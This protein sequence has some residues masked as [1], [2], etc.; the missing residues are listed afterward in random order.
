MSAFT[1]HSRPFRTAVA[2]ALLLAVVSGDVSAQYFGPNK[3]RWR[4][5]D[6]KVLQTEHFDIH[7]YPEAESAVQ[8]A[9]RLAERWYTR[10]ATVLEHQLSSRQPLILYAAHPH[11]QQTNVIQGFIGVGTGGVT[12]ALRR[13]I[14]LPFGA[15]GA[16]T[17]HVIGHE[18]VH[19]F[20]FDLASNTRERGLNLPLW[21]VEGMAEYLSIGP[22]DPHTAMW[23]RDAALNDRLPRVADLDNPEFF[24]YRF[25]Q[26]FWSYV[27][28]RWGDDIVG[29]AFRLALSVGPIPVLERLTGLTEEELSA[30][31]HAAIRESYGSV[32]QSRIVPADTGRPLFPDQ[33]EDEVTIAPALS[34][35]GRR[36][37]VLS[38]RELFSIDLYL[39]DVETGDV[40][41]RLSRGATDPHLDSL[42]F[43]N[44]AGSWDAEGRRFA[45]SSIRRGSPYVTV[46]DTESGDQIHEI[47][48]EQLGEIFHPALSPDASAIAFS[49]I[50]GG[51]TDLYLYEF[52]SAELTRLTE[53][54]ASDQQPEWSP[55]GRQIVFTTERFS[56]QPSTLTF[57]PL[58]L[59]VLD[60]ESREMKAIALPREF[61]E[62]KHLSPQWGPGGRTLYFVSDL[63]GVS[64]VFRL[65]ISTGQV[66]PVTRLAT[67]ATGITASSPALSVAAN[68]GRIAFSTLWRGAYS[69]VLVDGDGSRSPGLAEH[70]RAEAATLPPLRR[71]DPA[72]PQLLAKE[73][74]GLPAPQAFRTVDYEPRLQL[75]YIGQPTVGVGADA[76]GTYMGGGVSFLFS[77]L[78]GDQ[79][80]G[81]SA[82]IQGDL[83]D[84]SGQVVYLNRRSRLGWGGVGEQMSYRSGFFSQ[85]LD[86][87]N[88]QPAV[89]EEL[90]EVRQIHRQLAG[91][92][93]YPFSRAQR[94]ELTGGF[95]SIGM[96]AEVLSQ[97]FNIDTGEFLGESL[98]EVPTGFDTVN[99]GEAAAA[100]VYDTGIN[101]PTSPLLGR[102]YRFEVTQTAGGLNFTS[103][104]GDVRQYVMPFR[105]V[106]LA[107]RVLAFGRYGSDI[108]DPRLS[109]LYLGYP[110]LVRGYEWQS[111]ESR[112]CNPNPE[113][114]CPELDRLLGDRVAVANAEVRFPLVGVFTGDLDYGPIPV[115][116][117]LFADA[118][119]AWSGNRNPS[120]GDDL[121]RSVGAGVRV[122]ALGFAIL[123]FAAVRPLDRDRG[124]LF[125]FGLRPGF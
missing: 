21:F 36:V 51:L 115:E 82:Q 65:D 105:P 58:Q 121:I 113:S 46:V 38:S 16:D 81:A 112:E 120:F 54:L 75:D 43:V 110:S 59:A 62:A 79:M 116:G 71:Q 111:F 95:R 86:V 107:G 78:L 1:S 90:T 6:F 118:G 44:A 13:R 2:G 33:D 56:S 45:F 55:D 96:S 74:L 66:T 53:D 40:I 11:F 9:A 93:E 3:V 103:L 77:D 100:L 57:G 30:Q 25:G 73:T 97:A 32:M 48:F 24:P 31:W 99:L 10:L 109:P 39:A 84:F 34:P 20:Q 63:Q 12:E 72:V 102:R 42:Q 41:R 22:L 61:L 88:G 70:T 14:A 119:I 87:V 89:I 106:T 92:L 19:A 94:V 104:L 23:L 27:A 108:A 52:A 5:F 50:Q 29:D 83:Q 67:G 60:R 47:E 114:E 69:V 101:G 17:D 68:T 64:D 28:G 76:F 117:L 7:Y 37:M 15:S 98:E 91:L 80:V 35:D 4:T 18:L 49:A 85:R 123:E 26:A 124:W 8:D 122:N 125:S